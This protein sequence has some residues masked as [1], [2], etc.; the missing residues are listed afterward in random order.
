M[1]GFDPSSID[2]SDPIEANRQLKLQLARLE[3]AHGQGDPALAAAHPEA[4]E[5]GEGGHDYEDGGGGMQAKSLGHR[6][7]VH[8]AYQK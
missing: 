6:V 8:Y 4:H 5:D 2:W 3:A 7:R 1:S